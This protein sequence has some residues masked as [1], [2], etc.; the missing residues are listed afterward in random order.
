MKPVSASSRLL[1]RRRASRSVPLLPARLRQFDPLQRPAAFA[2]ARVLALPGLLLAALLVHGGIGYGAAFL[3]SLVAAPQRPAQPGAAIR[4][5]IREAVPP[6]PPEVEQ[7]AASPAEPEP[8][9]APRAAPVREHRRRPARP[10]GPAPAR[11]IVG[12]DLG[13]TVEGG[14]GPTF[15]TGNSLDGATARRAAAPVAVGPAPP[16]RAATTLGPGLSRPRRLRA[17]R[18]PYPAMYRER[19]IEDDVVVR[20]HL[21]DQGRVERVEL[22]GP[23]IHQEF[24][25][26]AR[27]TALRERF[28][29]ARRNG[30][31][32]P[33]ALT[34]AYRFRLA[35]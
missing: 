16:N 35:D 20:V 12:L 25:R 2:G 26:A 6:R 21:D 32:I 23:S 22:V 10:A 15:A 7:T 8:E 31:P 34:F 11:R 29:P 9:P 5:V 24:N 17:V 19:G 4:V 18:P 30:R 13:S 28:A 1:R 3:A 33:F 27:Q 14:S